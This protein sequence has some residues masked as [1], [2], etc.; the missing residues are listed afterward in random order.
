MV[1]RVTD[2]PPSRFRR[3]VAVAALLALA[4]GAS[5]AESFTIFGI[6][7]DTGNPGE[8]P[9]VTFN[10]ALGNYLVLAHEE[11]ELANRRVKWT[12]S[13]VNVYVPRLLEAGL[14]D[15]YDVDYNVET[16]TFLAAWS[17]G[18]AI[19]A[20]RLNRYGQ[21]LGA[22]FSLSSS[23]SRVAVSYIDGRDR[24]LVA[25][26]GTSLKG[27]VVHGNGSLDGSAFEL[28][29]APVGLGSLDYSPIDQEFLVVWQESSLY[30]QFF[31]EAGAKVGSRLTVSAEGGDAGVSFGEGADKWLVVWE[32]TGDPCPPPAFGTFR[33]IRG[34]FV[35][36]ATALPVFTLATEGCWEDSGVQ[37]PG[38]AYSPSSGDFLVVW[39]SYSMGAGSVDGRW[40]A[41]EGPVGASC[42]IDE[43]AEFAAPAGSRFLGCSSAQK[44]CL[45]TYVEPD[46]DPAPTIVWGSLVAV[47]FRSLTMSYLGSGSGVVSTDPPTSDPDWCWGDF[48]KGTV[49]TLQPE[50]DPDSEFAGFGGDADCL[51]S[52]VTMD[53]N[54]SCTATFDLKPLLTVAKTGG[55][56]GTVTS[57]PAGISCGP[58]CAER[59][60]NGEEVEL[61][62]TPGWGSQFDG[63]GGDPDCSDGTVT[64]T[65]DLACEVRFE[66]CSIPSEV[67]VTDTTIDTD[68]THEACNRLV[69]GP[70]VVVASSGRCELRAG[71]EVVFVE[72]V[73]IESGGEMMVALGPPVPP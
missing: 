4:A 3:K 19:L 8:A 58:D 35:Q 21:P 56:S 26:E 5:R 16:G 20:R 15:F 6:F 46:L 47:G 40:V 55:G 57:S 13:G 60:F 68:V 42:A 29:G 36:D 7:P 41:P 52:V 49:V 66:L 28:S 24:W 11:G 23:P 39:W 31:T 64:M 45:V 18:S 14:V 51:D 34:R 63:W 67:T 37:S 70:A 33:H 72:P 50:P 43:Y 48:E 27:Q 38:V 22:T 17:S 12:H 71:N 65:F 69:V 54:K 30:G 61:T 73:R 10:S 44:R 62:A 2:R 25:W 32:E 1:G 59:F 9:A 53:S